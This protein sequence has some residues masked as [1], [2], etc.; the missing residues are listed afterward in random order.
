VLRRT[1]PVVIRWLD[2]LSSK[3]EPNARG[4]PSGSRTL[5]AYLA[6]A[7]RQQSRHGNYAILVPRAA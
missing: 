7:Y 1:R 3:A 5:D 6:R 4:R 2:P